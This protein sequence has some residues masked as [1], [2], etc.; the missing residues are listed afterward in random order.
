MKKS[1]L[2]A[3]CLALFGCGA[4]RSAGFPQLVGGQPAN[5][6]DPVVSSIVGFNVTLHDFELRQPD[7]MSSNYSCG[8]TLVGPNHL[9]TAAHCFW[10]TNFLNTTNTRGHV[11]MSVASSLATVRFFWGP[12]RFPES[13]SYESP[14]VLGLPPL[15]RELGWRITAIELHPRFGETRAAG[16][17]SHDIALVTFEGEIPAALRQ[18]PLAEPDLDLGNG[19]LQVAGWGFP[20]EPRAAETD[21][22]TVSEARLAELNQKHGKPGILRQAEVPVASVSTADRTLTLQDRRFLLFRRDIAAACHGDSGSPGFTTDGRL[23]GL[24]SHGSDP[25]ARCDD[26]GAVYTDVRHY[27][28]WMKC[29]FATMGHPL[30]DLADDASATDCSLR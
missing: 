15:D 11:D 17:G 26:K 4:P 5:D 30:P 6:S 16:G 24:V 7:R 13:F 21:P 9:V 8:A 23:V 18:V 22:G 25:R 29:T 19:K 28:G 3:L 2:C 20:Y 10:K 12:R 27:Q 1:R 14:Y